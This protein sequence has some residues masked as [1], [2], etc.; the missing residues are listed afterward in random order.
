MPGPGR[1]TEREA[2]ASAEVTQIQQAAATLG[3]DSD[4]LIERLGLPVDVWLNDIA[5]LQAVPMSVWSFTIGG[6][7]V[8]KKWSSYR[9]Q[10]VMG[11]P[12]TASE[13]REASG[14]IK[15]LTALV[16]MQPQLDANYETVRSSA[17]PWTEQI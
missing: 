9:D 5:Y 14:I 1:I 11:R 8:L 6:Y 7:Q 16:L 12:L 3:E 13:A 17:F 2:Y 4:A 10:E 15:R